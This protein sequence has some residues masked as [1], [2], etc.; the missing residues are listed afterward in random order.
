LTNIINNLID[1]EP[2]KITIYVID[3]LYK[4]LTLR[5]RFHTPRMAVQI[6]DH[7]INIEASYEGQRGP[8]PP[9]VIPTTL[10]IHT[11]YETMDEYSITIGMNMLISPVVLI[12]ATFSWYVTLKTAWI[13]TSELSLV[14]GVTSA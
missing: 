3:V 12:L 13:P 10:T 11:P 14:F 1:H 6:V 7:L 2:V 9:V 4:D 5:A 8:L